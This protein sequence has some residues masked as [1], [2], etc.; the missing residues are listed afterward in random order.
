MGA[1]KI[2]TSQVLEPTLNIAV[3]HGWGSGCPG[4]PV[5]DRGGGDTGRPRMHFR[6][7]RGSSDPR[8]SQT[9]SLPDL[10]GRVFGPGF[11]LSY[12]LRREATEVWCTCDIPAGQ[13]LTR[14]KM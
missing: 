1:M 7:Q 12:E 13:D 3:Q 8:P 2:G 9:F 6:G 14:R 5:I 11:F 10:L 4:C